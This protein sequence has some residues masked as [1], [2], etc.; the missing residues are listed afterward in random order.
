MASALQARM[1]EVEKYREKIL[2][3]KLKDPILP[4][5][6]FY[7]DKIGGIKEAMKHKKETEKNQEKKVEDLKKAQEKG[8]ANDIK[9]KEVN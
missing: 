7:P 8:Q 5:V 1:C 9:K 3:T 6:N 4:C 2:I